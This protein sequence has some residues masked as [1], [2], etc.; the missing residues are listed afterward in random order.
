MNIHINEEHFTVEH[1]FRGSQP[2][3]QFKRLQHD[4]YVPL[5]W[6]TLPVSSLG[7]SL[8]H[9]SVVR[10]QVTPQLPRRKPICCP[11]GS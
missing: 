11:P 6:T 7:S 4:E 1:L 9:V 2:F 3:Q 10:T 5:K 8:K